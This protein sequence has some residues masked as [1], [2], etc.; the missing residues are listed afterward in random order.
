MVKGT[1]AKKRSAQRKE[2]AKQRA[3]QRQRQGLL[4]GAG[5]TAA[6]L[7]LVALGVWWYVD[8]RSPSEVSAQALYQFA[9]A[10]FHSLAFDPDDAETAYFGHHGGLKISHDGGE[11]WQD[12]PLSDV[13]AMQLAMPGNGSKRMYAAGHNVFYVSND[14]GETW[15]SQPNNLPGLDLHTFAGSF[16]DPLRLYTAPVGQGIFTSDDGGA[17]WTPITMPLGGGGSLALAVAPDD[18]LHLYAG[19]GGQMSESFDGGQ[20]WQEQSGPGG[21]IVSMTISHEAAPALY[22]GTDQGLF[23]R[24][25]SGPWQRLSIETSGVVLA[26]A[27]SPTQPTHVAIVDHGGNFYRSDDG[28]QTWERS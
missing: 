24:T 14:G 2:A 5:V 13:D 3:Q 9:T 8:G 6:A 20:T 25:A 1:T 27:A 12:A 17:T 10:D 4:I 21:I 23:K 15:Q 11:S 22:A 19:A 28:G 7:I 18:P 26:V 16:S